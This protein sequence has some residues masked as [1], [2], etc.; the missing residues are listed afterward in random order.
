MSLLDFRKGVIK[1][2]AGRFI[3]TYTA[4][5]GLGR[6]RRAERILCILY[7]EGERRK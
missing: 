5:G 2:E 6:S 7:I 3:G 4:G 1:T